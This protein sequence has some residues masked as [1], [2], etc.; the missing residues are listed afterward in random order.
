MQNFPTVVYCEKPIEALVK[1]PWYALSNFAYLG[2]GIVLLSK[3]K[4]AIAK[5]FG[6]LSIAIGLA[7]LLYDSLYTYWA[8]LIDLSMMLLFATTLIYSSSIRIFDR[9]KIVATLSLLIVFAM[10]LIVALRGYSGNIIF[11]IYVSL[12]LGLETLLSRRKIHTGY[13]HLIMALILFFLGAIFWYLDASEVYCLQLGL[14]NG[15][16]I[17]HYLGASSVYFLYKFY[18][19]QAEK[20]I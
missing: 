8:Q 2:L 16:A 15:R 11:G 4:D 1:R 5:R 6:Y 17:F 7:S 13:N 12:F 9:K 3:K 20:V 10:I 18:S 19:L 14:L